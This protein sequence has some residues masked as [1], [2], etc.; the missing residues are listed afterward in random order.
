M[1]K[2]TL[3]KKAV[4]ET[5]FLKCGSYGFQGSGKT[6]TGW[7]IGSGLHKYIKEF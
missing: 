4:N 1:A 5:S 3:F 7:I 2:P 6:F